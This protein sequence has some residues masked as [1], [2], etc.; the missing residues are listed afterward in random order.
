MTADHGSKA[1]GRKQG[2]VKTRR[3]I[4][5][6]KVLCTAVS[7]SINRIC[8]EQ[9]FLNQFRDSEKWNEAEKAWKIGQMLGLKSNEVDEE[10][11][12]KMLKMEIRKVEEA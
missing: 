3:N 6:S 9:S 8:K 12:R 11:V 10:V 5:K 2:K 4:Y 1:S 7:A